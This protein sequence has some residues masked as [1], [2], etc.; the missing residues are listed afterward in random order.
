M[1]KECNFI[2]KDLLKPKKEYFPMSIYIK[3]QKWVVQDK[4]LEQ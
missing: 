4:V 1:N 2:I 3:E